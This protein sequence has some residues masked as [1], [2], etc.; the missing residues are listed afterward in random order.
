MNRVA[1]GASYNYSPTADGLYS[2]P[3]IDM[4][5]QLLASVYRNEVS[6]DLYCRFSS[7]GNNDIVL[8][9]GDSLL[10]GNGSSPTIAINNTPKFVVAYIDSSH[11]IN[12]RI[13]Y[14]N[15]NGAP[16]WYDAAVTLDT[17]MAQKCSIA[18]DDNNNV[19]LTYEELG[20]HKLYYGIGS[21]DYTRHNKINWHRAKY[22]T[23]GINPCVAINNSGYFLEVHQSENFD[24][25]Y[26]TLG[27][28]NTD[29]T[30]HIYKQD[31]YKGVSK[32][33]ASISPAISLNDNGIAVEVHA[34]GKSKD[35]S[36][37]FIQFH[38]DTQNHVLVKDY[39]QKYCLDS[40]ADIDG[41][42]G[43][44]PKVALN[45]AGNAV[46]MYQTVKHNH[47]FACISRLWDR[48][49]WMNN[50]QE[51]PL[52]DLAIPGSH[53]AAMST[54]S[55]S[56]EFVGATSGNTQTQLLCVE[57]QLKAGIRYFDIRPALKINASF[58]V[59]DY[60]TGH[61]SNTAVGIK[62]CYGESLDDILTGVKS[63]LEQYPTEVVILKFS[64]FF[65]CGSDTEFLK[66]SSL[67]L[68]TKQEIINS[69]ISRIRSKLG[70]NR[71]LAS[72]SGRVSQTQL[73]YLKGKA[74][75]VFDVSEL[76]GLQISRVMSYL[77]FDP[78]PSNAG[79]A[80]LVVFDRYSKTNDV[81]VMMS[82]N[83][84]SDPQYPGQEYA[85]LNSNYHGGDLFLL[86]WTLTLSD[87]DSLNPGTYDIMELAQKAT[88]NLSTQ[89]V[90][91]CTDANGIDRIK[92]PN[93]IYTDI[94]AGGSTDVCEWINSRHIK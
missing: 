19:V 63:F 56:S 82:K 52:C 81:E 77:D 49:S 4:N 34:T 57:D 62:G 11:N 25:I 1:F 88:G 47:L 61:F 85:L 16:V 60:K 6:L 73:K 78:S 15:Q 37:Y 45:N 79:Q 35:Y 43:K 18:I 29:G 67:P 26:Y 32:N 76:P 48:S 10:A 5:E 41:M 13:G 54:T 21:F 91:L 71:I 92:F 42:G 9:F 31:E 93:I 75:I 83:L 22:Y 68:N 23:D 20:T 3:D 55:G 7:I 69:L 28:M 74:I 33:S 2:S 44:F 53:D 17:I 14:F 58:S 65:L 46:Q 72:V 80:D 90:A 51:K 8:N 64:H 24:S 59:T 66:D 30:I 27:K 86:S 94:C 70:D 39:E 38:I 89:I 87:T 40:R 12:Y 50:Y 36:L 84:P